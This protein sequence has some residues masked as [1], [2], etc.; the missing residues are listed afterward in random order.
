MLHGGCVLPFFIGNPAWCLTSLVIGFQ[1]CLDGGGE[2]LLCALDGGCIID[3]LAGMLK[4]EPPS[5]VAGAAAA[6][7][8]IGSASNAGKALIEAS[9]AVPALLCVIQRSI[10][11]WNPENEPDLLCRYVRDVSRACL[12]VSLRGVFH[13]IS[14]YRRPH[15]HIAPVHLPVNF[16]PCLFHVCVSR[17]F[18]SN[19]PFKRG[20]YLKLSAVRPICALDCPTPCLHVMF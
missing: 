11:L 16:W 19:S 18:P 9:G 12:G 10:S 3:V 8:W 6:L 4:Q 13:D 15:M 7:G 1:D 2:D 17:Y 20:R 14:A 5:C